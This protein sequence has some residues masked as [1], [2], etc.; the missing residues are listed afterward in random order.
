MGV[1]TQQLGHPLYIIPLLGVTHIAG[2]VVIGFLH[3]GLEEWVGLVGRT[4]E[5]DQIP[6]WV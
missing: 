1:A 3:A 5:E 4:C 6:V 2:G